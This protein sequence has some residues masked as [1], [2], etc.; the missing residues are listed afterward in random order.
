MLTV[1]II[2]QRVKRESSGDYLTIISKHKIKCDNKGCAN[3]IIKVTR[4]SKSVRELIKKNGW[5][6]RRGKYYCK[7]CSEMKK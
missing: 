3:A 7:R 4:F 2:V 1:V 5:T 6:V